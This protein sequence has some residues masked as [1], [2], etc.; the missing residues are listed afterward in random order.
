MTGGVAYIHDPE[1]KFGLNCNLGTVDVEPLQADDL[2][3]VRL[4]I[5]NHF[6][7]TGSLRALD[8]LNHWADHQEAFVRVMPRE[9][10]AVLAK[11]SRQ[12][13][14]PEPAAGQIRNLPDMTLWQTQ[15]AS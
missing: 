4:L 11:A 12:Q 15:K 10:K 7:Y 9:Y 5:R 3:Q 14:Q 1:D 13:P 6:N 8:I 2:Q